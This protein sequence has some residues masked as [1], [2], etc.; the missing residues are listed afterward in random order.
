MCELYRCHIPVSVGRNQGFCNVNVKL[1]VYVVQELCLSAL[2]P[3]STAFLFLVV[4]A[5]IVYIFNFIFF[6][7]VGMC[8]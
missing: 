6:V 3:A 7:S 5:C 2:L 4:I 1:A 8:A